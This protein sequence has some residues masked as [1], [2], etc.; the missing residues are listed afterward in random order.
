M[1][2]RHL[3]SLATAK[4]W[5]RFERGVPGQ[6][7]YIVSTGSVPLEQ[8]MVEIHAPPEINLDAMRS[9]FL[10]DSI[11][12]KLQ[13]TDEVFDEEVFEREKLAFEKL[14]VDEWDRYEDPGWDWDCRDPADIVC[15]KLEREELRLIAYENHIHRDT[16]LGGLESDPNLFLP[17]TPIIRTSEDQN[18]CKKPHSASRLKA[19]VGTQRSRTR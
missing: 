9:G 6:P 11:E 13:P 17:S 19:A 2:R 18:G 10:H 7:N 14:L 1:C 3:K 16:I 12:G 8:E 15:D 4:K 5:A